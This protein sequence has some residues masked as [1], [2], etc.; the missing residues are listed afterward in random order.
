MPP[1]LLQY[2]GELAAIAVA[3]L[4]ALAG[5]LYQ[6]VSGHIS[7]MMMNLLKG[8][9]AIA[10]LG[11][12]IVIQGDF[13]PPLSLTLLL[14]LSLSG[15]LGITVGD[16]AY[17]QALP[18]LGTQKTM[19]I[20]TLSAPVTALLAWVF[21]HEGLSL[22]ALA[23]MVITLGGVGWVIAEETPQSKT[24]S[25]NRW[26]GLFWGLLSSFA[27]A[28]GALFS[29]VALSGTTL[30][31]LWATFIRLLTAAI[32]LFLVLLLARRKELNVRHV[33]LSI[34]R[35]LCTAALMGTFLG[36]YLTQVAFKYA[37]VGIAQTLLST[38]PIFVLPLVW[39]E[40]E[41]VSLRAVFGAIV[42]VA[43]IVLLF[44]AK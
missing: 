6:R 20:G 40:G 29:H 9:I 14:L 12:V 13:H 43:G 28:G 10:C 18:S 3:L 4:W 2:Q 11:T 41:K 42:A 33:R 23:G 22:G 16:T 31:P 15:F 25:A 26:T 30:S 5:V 35:Y 24:Q 7:S 1:S 27:G 32:S 21:L 37:N 19:L 39:R 38:S 17:F 36:I 8:L 34:W 44:T